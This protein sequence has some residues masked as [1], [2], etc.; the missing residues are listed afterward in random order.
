MLIK[1]YMLVLDLNKGLQTEKTRNMKFLHFGCLLS[2]CFFSTSRSGFY[3]ESEAKSKSRPVFFYYFF[4][5]GDITIGAKTVVHP[6]AK[7]I[8]ESGPIII[9]GCQTVPTYFLIWYNPNNLFMY[10]SVP[11]F[12]LQFAVE[13]GESEELALISKAI[14][15]IDWSIVADPHF[16]ADPDADPACHWCGSGS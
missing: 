15:L 3:S 11:L 16:D 13:G 12:T 5:L 8:A 14:V 1:M 7:I 4:L 9:G 6:K 2:S 10:R